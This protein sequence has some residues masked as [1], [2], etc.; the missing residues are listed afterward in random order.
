MRL[1]LLVV[2]LGKQQPEDPL[3]VLPE[4]VLDVKPPRR[5]RRLVPLLLLLGRRRGRRG[6]AIRRRR[7]SAATDDPPAAGAC[8]REASSFDLL[9]DLKWQALGFSGPTLR[10]VSTLVHT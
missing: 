3:A 7:R 4:K 9:L 6:I 2:D 1:L 5:R 10:N 8:A